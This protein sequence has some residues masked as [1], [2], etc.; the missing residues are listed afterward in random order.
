MLYLAAP[1]GANAGAKASTGL[2]RVVYTPS[3]D[4]EQRALIKGMKGEVNTSS[5]LQGYVKVRTYGL[6]L[7]PK[8]VPYTCI[9]FMHNNDI[10]YLTLLKKVFDHYL[11]QCFLRPMDMPLIGHII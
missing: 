2:V 9:F 3:P 10:F 8:C 1:G 6:S 4:S 11:K 7:I 5:K